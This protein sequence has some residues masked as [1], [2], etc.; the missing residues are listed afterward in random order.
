MVSIFVHILGKLPVNV[1]NVRFFF[2]M[3]E[4]YVPAYDVLYRGE[5]TTMQ[6]LLENSSLKFTTTHEHSHRGETIAMQS[7]EK[8][9]LRY[10]ET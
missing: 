1:S 6:S 7:F 10:K 3:G 9:L 2:G 8:R 4:Y 5:T